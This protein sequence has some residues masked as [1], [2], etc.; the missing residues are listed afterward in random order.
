MRK[1]RTQIQFSFWILK[2]I[3]EDLSNDNIKLIKLFEV[4][5]ILNA[6][7]EAPYIGAVSFDLLRCNVTSHTV[8]AITKAVVLPVVKVLHRRSVA[9][10]GRILQIVKS[11]WYSEYEQ[12]CDVSVNNQPL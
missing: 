2:L 8:T 4:M 11:V 3:H 12:R 9:V 5:Y 1:S 6:S 10:G 7:V